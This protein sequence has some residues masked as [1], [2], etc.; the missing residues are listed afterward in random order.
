M[1]LLNIH[2]ELIMELEIQIGNDMRNEKDSLQISNGYISDLTHPFFH[3][4]WFRL[5]M[6]I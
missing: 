3:F 6:T 1:T 2:L 4:C 5:L